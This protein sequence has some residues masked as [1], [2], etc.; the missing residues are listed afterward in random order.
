MS[1]FGSSIFWCLLQGITREAFSKRLKETE[2]NMVCLF[3]KHMIFDSSACALPLGFN[4][5]TC[6]IFQAENK[7]TFSPLIVVMLTLISPKLLFYSVMQYMCTI[8]YVPSR[9]GWMS[10]TDCLT[11][12][13]PC[14]GNPE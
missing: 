5:C 12:P 14:P 3:S 11:E 9:C 10:S 7:N 1:R 6:S 4:S 8:Q 2:W 13:K